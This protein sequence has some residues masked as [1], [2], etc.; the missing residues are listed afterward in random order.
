MKTFKKY[1]FL[2]AVSFSLTSCLVDDDVA[3]DAIIESTPDFVGFNSATRNALVTEGTG[4]Y[5]YTAPILV[6]GPNSQ[7]I[8]EDVQVEITVDPAST[9]IPGVHYNLNTTSATLLVENG[10]IGNIPFTVLS[11]DESISAPSTFTLILHITETSGGNGA[12]PSGRTGTL[13]INISYLCNSDLAGP[14]VTTSGP[15]ANVTI[16]ELADG[17]YQHNTLPGL[18][19]GGNAIPFEFSDSC[20]NITI[21]TLVLGGGYLVQGSGTVNPDTGVITING[22]ILYNGTTVDSG[23]F[24]DNSGNTYIYTPN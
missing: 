10:L 18:T 9:A 7:S 19:S 6:M 23:P 16:T 1:L 8:T 4:S 13:T 3:T 5:D 22:Y 15:F 2:L 14:Y 24:F 21:D 17:V 12:I 11:D 20:G